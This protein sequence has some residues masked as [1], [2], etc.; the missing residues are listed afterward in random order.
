MLRGPVNAIERMTQALSLPLTSHQSEAQH[1][2]QPHVQSVEVRVREM[3]R[4]V[5]DR[6][7]VDLYRLVGFN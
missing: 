2:G 7:I 3:I 5:F 6:H 4:I 1:V